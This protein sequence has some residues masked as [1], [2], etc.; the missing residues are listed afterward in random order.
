M[1]RN[2]LSGKR[3]P[4]RGCHMPFL[5]GL[6]PQTCK[7]KLPFRYPFMRTCKFSGWR[8]CTNN[9]MLN[10]KPGTFRLIWIATW[11]IFSRL[12][13]T[14]RHFRFRYPLGLYNIKGFHDLHLKVC[15]PAC[16][17]HCTEPPG[18]N[19]GKCCKNLE[20]SSSAS[21]SS[22]T[23]LCVWGDGLSRSDQEEVYVFILSD[24]GVLRFLGNL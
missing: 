8:T 3:D 10:T 11:T 5:S 9:I 17:Q 4:H 7:Q 24:M 14:K 20:E 15:F 16:L 18:P 23:R 2:K 1:H 19:G 12:V 6:P 22:G 13:G 21:S